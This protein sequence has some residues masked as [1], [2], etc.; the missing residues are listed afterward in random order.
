MSLNYH[1]IYQLYLSISKGNYHTRQQHS[2]QYKTRGEHTSNHHQQHH[3]ERGGGVQ[4]NRSHDETL[5]APPRSENPWKNKQSAVEL[6][7]NSTGAATGDSP[8][9]SRTRNSESQG[10]GSVVNAAADALAS[11]STSAA[12]PPY[13]R[14]QINANSVIRKQ[15]NN[16]PRGDNRLFVDYLFRRI[17]SIKNSSGFIFYYT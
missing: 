7:S 13:Q 4:H 10:H 2:H 15:E 1:N 9:Q 17:Q 8:Q 12:A 14:R 5:P 11:S 6:F 3:Q 16:R